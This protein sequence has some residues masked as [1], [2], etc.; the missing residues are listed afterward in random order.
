MSELPL[1]QVRTLLAVVDEGSFDAAA[2]ALRLTPSAVSQRIKAL[3]RRVGR[4]LVLRTKP[5]G[6]TGS[7]E[8]LVRLARQLVRL[9]DD[10]AA[11]LGLPVPGAEGAADGGAEAGRA[12]TLAVA[13]NADS[14]ATWFLP[15]LSQLPAD[16]RVCFELHKEDQAR[17]ADLLRQGLVSAA[18]TAAPHPV[19]GCTVR[20]LG[21][22]AYRACATPDFVE[23]WLGV[24][25]LAETLP[26]APV[27]VFNRDD[28]LQDAFLRG[29]APGAEPGRLRHSIPASDAYVRA[30]AAG[31]GWGMLPDE[32]EAQL[33]PGTVVDLAP[34]RTVEVA[35][36]WQQWKLD[37]PPLAALAT[38]V[39][40]AAAG[41]LTPP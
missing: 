30:V 29:L 39:A 2:Q 8:V 25:P 32:Q 15:A 18:I 9:E 22:M 1:D 13:V 10:A 17:T 7:G 28:D 21:S 16:L 24:G 40:R 26:S 19:A 35:L 4:V 20:P 14:L 6:P 34:G 41:T 37:S 36:Y 33:P 31:L 11:E 5:V 38:A 3:E 23:R 12:T 27:I